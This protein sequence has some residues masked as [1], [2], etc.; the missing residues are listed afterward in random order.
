MTTRTMISGFR[1]WG[2]CWE[3]EC[4]CLGWREVEEVYCE[5]MSCLISDGRVSWNRFRIYV[6]FNK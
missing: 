1:V 3:N 6:W 5:E 2:V 4:G